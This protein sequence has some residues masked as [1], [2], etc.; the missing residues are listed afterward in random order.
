MKTSYGYAGEDP[1]SFTD[2][3]GLWVKL[4]SQWVGSPK[5]RSTDPGNPFRHDY[6]DVSGKFIGFYSAPGSNPQWGKGVV[7]GQGEQDGGRCSTI[8]DDPKFDVYVLQAV[9]EEGVPTYCAVAS[10]SWGILG[11][12]PQLAGARNCQS[13]AS[14]VLRK[15]KKNYR[16]HEKETC[17]TCFKTDMF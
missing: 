14:D 6:L 1:V 4:C 10:M 17:I 9:Q 3:L 12:G 11:L 5:N 8:C 15:A 7:A 2:P 16:A 13:W